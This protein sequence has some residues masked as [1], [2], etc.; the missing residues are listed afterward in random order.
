MVTCYIHISI[1]NTMSPQL[2]RLFVLTS[3]VPALTSLFLNPV[4]A[5]ARRGERDYREFFLEQQVKKFFRSSTNR[6]VGNTT[7]M[8]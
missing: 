1:S 2:R 5:K 4:L 7:R 6:G 3:W 8:A